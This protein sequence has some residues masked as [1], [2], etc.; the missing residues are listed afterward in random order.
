MPPL[1]YSHK[2]HYSILKEVGY[3]IIYSLPCYLIPLTIFTLNG[4][5][6]PNPFQ[7]SNLNEKSKTEIN[8]EHSINTYEFNY[9][10]KD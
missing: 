6:E 1:Q 3:L 5:F 2:K 4:E 10:S 8:L 7:W 9:I